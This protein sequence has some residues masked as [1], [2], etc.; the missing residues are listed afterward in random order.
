MAPQTE[1]ALFSFR[2]NISVQNKIKVNCLS[3]IFNK[4]FTLL[5]NFVIQLGLCRVS[6]FGTYLNLILLHML[7]MH[8]TYVELQV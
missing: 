8:H 1:T 4:I 6:F 7:C 3:Y 5:L 2:R